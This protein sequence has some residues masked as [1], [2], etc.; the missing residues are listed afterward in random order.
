MHAF[1]NIRVPHEVKNQRALVYST[2]HF[3]SFLDCL[4]SPLG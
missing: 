3:G 2:H 4:G 1:M